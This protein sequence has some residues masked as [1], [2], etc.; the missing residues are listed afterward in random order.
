[1][2]ESFSWARRLNLIP[3]RSVPGPGVVKRLETRAGLGLYSIAAKQENNPGSLIKRHSMPCAWRRPLARHHAPASAIPLPRIV[4]ILII[5]AD[6]AKE[7]YLLAPGIVRH[8][9]MPPAPRTHSGDFEP[10]LATPFPRIFIPASRGR[11]S[12]VQHRLPPRRIVHHDVVIARANPGISHLPPGLA[13]PFPGVRQEIRESSLHAEPA[14][15]NQPFAT[16]VERR[17]A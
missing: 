10:L 17:S 1:M 13:I 15:Q 8:P 7:D 5:L 3:M 14:E 16:R 6:P 9:K 12:A 4:V 11:L 2:H